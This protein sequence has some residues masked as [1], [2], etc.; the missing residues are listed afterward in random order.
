MLSRRGCL[1]NSF[2]PVARVPALLA[3]VRAALPGISRAFASAWARRDRLGE[4]E[5]M[6]AFYA[7]LPAAS[8]SEAVL[9][10]RPDDLAVLPVRGVSWSDWGEPGRVLRTLARL[11]VRPD[12]APPAVAL[13]AG[14]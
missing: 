4:W 1:W 12:C 11:G 2:V 6:R 3:L 14:A 5:A 7:G 9:G 13:P 10:G 8:F